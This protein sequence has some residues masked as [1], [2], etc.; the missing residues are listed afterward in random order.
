M[1]NL[2]SS[3]TTAGVEMQDQAHTKKKLNL[4]PDS[5]IP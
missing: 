3:N 1:Q 5:F 4:K 2:T